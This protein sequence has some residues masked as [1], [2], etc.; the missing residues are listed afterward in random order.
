VTVISETGAAWDDAATRAS[1]L[2][3][4]RIGRAGLATSLVCFVGF[5]VYITHLQDHANWLLLRP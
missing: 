5:L 1:F 3:A 4:R 2:R